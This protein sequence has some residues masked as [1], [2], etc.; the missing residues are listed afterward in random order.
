MTF[1]EYVAARRQGLQR[2]AYLLT[3]DA[4]RAQDLVQTALLEAYLRWRKVGRAEHPDAYVRRIITNEHL[5]WRKRRWSRE[6]PTDPQDR[7]G[8]EPD[9]V[10]WD[11]T[12]PA[13]RVADH[14]QLQRALA[15]VSPHQRAVLVLRHYEGYDDAA[16]AHV[17]GASEAT[18]R[19]HASRGL[20]RM[21]AELASPAAPPP[22]SP[23]LFV[24]ERS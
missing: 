10:G 11:V 7:G 8:P 22:S 1:E 2:Y 16:I 9:P 13:V 15:R 12:D 21:R 3:G 4:H 20:A 24:Q 14:D 19:S 6:D 23:F 17:L 18:V 5:N